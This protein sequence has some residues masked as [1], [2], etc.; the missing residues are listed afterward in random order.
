MGID[1]SEFDNPDAVWKA[2]ECDRDELITL[3]RSDEK[4]GRL[5]RDTLADWLEGKLL[6]VKLPKSRPNGYHPDPI[7]LKLY[8]GHNPTTDLG[9]AGARYEH[10]RRFIR[11]KK[12]HLKKA[13]RFHRSPEWLLKKIAERHGIDPD[14]FDGYLKRSRPKP[15]ARLWRTEE[16][17][18]RRRREIA[19][20]IR[21]AKKRPKG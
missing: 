15:Q 6:P 16:Y 4:L 20:E 12:W 17:V 18:E 8:Y 2:V 5:F 13:G 11:K 9:Y 1:I 21:R 3:L 19:L 14:K 7:I 10:F